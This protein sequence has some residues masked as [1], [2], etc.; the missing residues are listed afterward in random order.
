MQGG[1]TLCETSDGGADKCICVIKIISDEVRRELATR[2]PYVS[3][4]WCCAPDADKK[5]G[6]PNSHSFHLPIPKPGE[7]RRRDEQEPLFARAREEALFDGGGEET[8]VVEG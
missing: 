2:F 8:S 3:G 1:A 6:M 5:R 7:T 4:S